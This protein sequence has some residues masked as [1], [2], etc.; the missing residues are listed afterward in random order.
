MANE[1]NFWQLWA[2]HLVYLEDNHLDLRTINALVE[3]IASPVLVVGG[4][5]GLL[6]NE[7][8]NKGFQVDG[9]DSSPEMVKLAEQRR[10][11]KLVLTDGSTLP[12][13]DNSHETSIIAT[14]VVDFLDDDNQIRSIIEETSRVSKKGG[15]LLISFYKVHPITEKFLERIGIITKHGTMRRR[16]LFELSR[17]EPMDFIAAIRKEANLSLFSAIAELIKLQLLLPKQERL[18]TKHLGTILKSADN[19]DE[20]INS[21]SE[22]IPYRNRESILALFKKLDLPIDELLDFETCF[23]AVARAKP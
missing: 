15:N 4:G 10:G 20:L 3:K 22:I 16:R 8:Q 13:A 23:V 17:L 2:P 6:V 12:F 18:L 14:G 1:S 9:V 19:A 7:L 21:V 5:Q 11:V